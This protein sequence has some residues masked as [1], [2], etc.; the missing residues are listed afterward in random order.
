MNGHLSIL[1]PMSDRV[2]TILVWQEFNCSCSIENKRTEFFKRMKSYKKFRTELENRYSIIQVEPLR[3]V[4]GLLWVSVRFSCQIKT[5]F[6][7]IYH[8]I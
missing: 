7:H 6:N 4:C 2:S 8:S 3:V 5:Y 1:D